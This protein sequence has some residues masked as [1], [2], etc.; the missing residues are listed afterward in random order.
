MQHGAR[1]VLV[2][3]VDGH[4]YGVDS[5]AVQE[6]VRAVQPARLPEAPAVVAGVI[7][8]RGA[9]VPLIDLR[10]RFGLTRTPV[11][12]SDVFVIVKSATRTL[13]LIADAVNELVR[14]P[15]NSIVAVQES[16]PSASFL[17]G[18][19][20]LPDGVLLLC[21]IELFLDQLERSLLDRALQSAPET[22]A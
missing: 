15:E 22:H 11:R 13:A 5:R 2:F 3:E 4:R 7:N 20:L 14:V 18:A 9:L 1:V 10:T 21:D 19:A 12:A 16:V 6:I 8:A 17:A